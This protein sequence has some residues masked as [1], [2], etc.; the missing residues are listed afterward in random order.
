MPTVALVGYTNAGKTTLFNLLTL[1]RARGHPERSRGVTGG[2]AV[3]SDAL[4]VTL[5][6]L[7]RKVKLPDRRELLVSDTV[8]FIERLPHSLVA[9]F[10]ATLEEVAGADLL[11]HVIDAS[12]TDRTR[13]MEAVASVLGEVG[14]GRVPAV[15][16]FNKCDRLD[17]GERARLRALHPGALCVSA[18]TGEGRDE[19]IA[20]M[21]TRLGLDTERVSL[22]FPP[23]GEASRERVAELYRVGR[24]VRHVA[25]DH[26]VS[27]EAE[28]P[29]RLVPRFD[30]V[31]SSL[32]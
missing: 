2:E 10:R 5:D 4:F 11:L 16:I 20:A 30:D 14:A 17:E 19:V 28:I 32:R 31:R 7:V 24:I 22:S 18:L 6:P 9:A 1:R 21:E 25:S 29:R 15:E 8:G 12:S 27:I 3:A 23:N 13:Q 26:E